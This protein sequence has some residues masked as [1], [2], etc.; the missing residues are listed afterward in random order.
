MIVD[1]NNNTEERARIIQ[2]FNWK[3]RDITNVVEDI[4]VQGFNTILISPIQGLKQPLSDWWLLYQPTNYKIGNDLGTKE[5]LVNLCNVASAYGVRIMVDVVLHHVAN[6]EG[7]DL[8]DKVDNE[9]KNLDN[10]FYE[11]SFKLTDNYNDHY[12]AT[13]YSLGGLPALNLNNTHLRKLQFDFLKELVNCG[14][15]CFRFDA[16]KHLSDDN[17]YFE[18]M[19]EEVGEEYIKNSIGEIIEN[20]PRKIIELYKKY[21]NIACGYTD[22]RKENKEVIWSYSH[23]DEFSFKNIAPDNN[24]LINSYRYLNDNYKADLLFYVRPFNNTWRDYRIREIN[25]K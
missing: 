10:L 19:M 21:M 5:D 7:N 1:Y 2:M 20:P 18:E 12:I 11:D 6:R 23:D 4:K 24:S 13:H 3:L 14:V 9:I 22:D 17:N 16:L 25:K 8:S 15:S